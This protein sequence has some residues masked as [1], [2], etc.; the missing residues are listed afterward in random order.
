MQRGL[1]TV[2]R[3]F[4]IRTPAQCLDQVVFDTTDDGHVQGG[5]PRAPHGFVVFSALV[6]GEHVYCVVDGA[7]FARRSK[8][9]DLV[10]RIRERV[11]QNA[12][13]I[14]LLP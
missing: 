2:A 6:E 7:C 3:C 8:P 9:A 12:A 1:S 10:P 14:I 4:P 11:T 5:E 13:K